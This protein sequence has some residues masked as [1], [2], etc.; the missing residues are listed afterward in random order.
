MLGG[1]FFVPGKF[2]QIIT[3]RPDT[4]HIGHWFETGEIV[5]CMDVVVSGSDK[6]LIHKEPEFQASHLK[7]YFMNNKGEVQVLATGD[8]RRCRT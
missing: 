5:K 1:R 8:V 4:K 7:G 6:S 2:Y 3:H